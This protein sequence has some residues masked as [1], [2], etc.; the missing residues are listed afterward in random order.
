M[1]FLFQMHFPKLFVLVLKSSKTKIFE[2][3][4]LF[5]YS[6]PLYS[7]KKKEIKPAVHRVEF[8]WNNSTHSL[9]STQPL[10]LWSSLS[11]YRRG[12]RSSRPEV[13]CKKV[14]LKK[15]YKIHRKN[16]IQ[17]ETLAQ[18][19]SCEFCEIFKNTYFYRTPLTVVSVVS[20]T[21][22]PRLVQFPSLSAQVLVKKPWV[23]RSFPYFRWTLAAWKCLYSKLIRTRKTRIMS[24]N[25]FYTVS[26]SYKNCYNQKCIRNLSSIYDGAFLQKYGFFKC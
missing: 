3:I 1:N 8:V 21:T 20:D 12:Y 26:F 22:T 16:P 25:N 4:I 9:L 10:K 6:I 19:F 18:V 24:M 14:V 11:G 15:I 5:Y 23:S 13:F 17:K 2:K 7:W